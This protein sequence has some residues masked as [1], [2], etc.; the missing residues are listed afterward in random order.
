MR[1]AFQRIAP[2]L[3][4]VLPWMGAAL[5]V[6]AAIFAVHSWRFSHVRVRS[7]AT[8]TENIPVFAKQGGILY[9]PRLRFRTPDG[10]IVQVLAPPGSDEIEFSAGETVPVL[11]KAS[12]PQDAIIATAWRAYHAAIVLGLWG[13]ALFDAGW[14]LRVMAARRNG[15]TSPP[16]A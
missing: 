8:V 1:N 9:F 7:I 12:T 15:M 3:A 6:A 16:K 13:T 10:K 11:Y 2:S 4:A 5:L 14:I